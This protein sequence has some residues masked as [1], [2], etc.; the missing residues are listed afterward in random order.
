[1]VLPAGLGLASAVAPWF[2]NKFFPNKSNTEKASSV[3]N[4]DYGAQPGYQDI[5]KLLQNSPERQPFNADQ[6]NQTF[7]QSVADPSLKYYEERIRP[8]TQSAYQSPS[9]IYTAGMKEALDQGA[10][11]LASS[12]AGMRANYLQQGQEN[13]ANQRYN[14]I[15]QQIGLWDKQ[16]GQT[17]SFLESPQE[18]SLQ[19]L[20]GQL[21][22]ILPNIDWKSIFSK[23]SQGNPNQDFDRNQMTNM[24]PSLSNSYNPAAGRDSRGGIYNYI[25]GQL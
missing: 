5:M 23:N 9:G 15:A 7:N 11:D 21:T 4:F 8:S 6:Y 1:M 22:K 16:A 19:S 25:G 20:L 3:T 12:L 17:H 24:A 18:S 13:H 14:N 10:G 2:L